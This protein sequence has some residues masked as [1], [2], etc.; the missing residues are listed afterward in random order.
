MYQNSGLCQEAEGSGVSASEA[1]VG[2]KILWQQI[3][4]CRIPHASPHNLGYVAVLV[5]FVFAV[6]KCLVEAP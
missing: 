6:M 2:V 4:S 1:R 3:S 5:I